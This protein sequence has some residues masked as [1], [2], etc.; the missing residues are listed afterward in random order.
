MLS[1]FLVK[2]LAVSALLCALPLLLY[3]MLVPNADALP[4][5]AQ[6]QGGEKVLG[7]AR[8]DAP[9]LIEGDAIMPRFMRASFAGESV[10]LEN[11]YIKL[12]VFKR[13]GGWGWGEIYAPDG[14]LMAVLDHLGE[15]MLRDQDIP[16]RLEATAYT[17][18][19][20]TDGE[21]LVFQVQSV[22]AQDK[23]AGSSFEEWMRYPF[24]QPV[25]VG[26]VTLTLAPDKPLI[27][28]SC[29]Y[30]STGNFYAR[31]V[32]GPWLRVGQDSFGTAKDDAIFPGVEWLI[33][34]EWSS[35]TD[36][37][38][39]PWAKRVVPHPN[40]VSIPLMTL[41]H[42]GTAITMSWDPLQDATRWFNYRAHRPQPVFASPN[43][44][45]RL[46]NTLM[47]LM[48]PDA[49]VESQENQVYAEPPLMLHLEQRI[50]FDAEIRLSNG[51]SLQGVVDWIT[52]HG[53]PEAALR[54]PFREA[55][56]RI[57]EAYNTNLWHDGE[58]FGIPQR[59]QIRPRP[60]QF[61]ARYLKEYGGTPLATELEEKVAWCNEQTGTPSG[62]V[63]D[64]DTLESRGQ[65][66]LDIQQENG[67]FL[68]EP[69]GRHYRKDDFVI[70]RA[71]I[72]PMGLAQDTALDICMLPATELL[73]LGEQTGNQMFLDAAKKTLEFCMPMTRPEGGDFWET[74]LHAPN[75]LAAGHAAIAYYRGYEVL[76]D[77]RYRDKA[78]YWIRSV[79]PFTHLWEPADIAMMYNTKP[80]LTSSD[81][82]FANWV[83]DHV[84]WE[85]LSVFAASAERG[86]H[87]NVIDPHVDWR[88]YHEGIT[89]AA[90]RWISDHTRND[91]RPHN[92]PE[93]LE[94]YKRGAFDGCYPD[95]FN[96]T[97]GNY[98]GMLIPPDAIARNILAV[99]DYE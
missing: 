52:A 18:E 20:T 16:M 3:T 53:M 50:D 33:D 88:R 94:A 80:C 39:D 73:D 72:E 36:W 79:V 87:W 55:L 9:A 93:T 89:A 62:S 34:D 8:P 17:L 40:K 59:G 26:E 77:A 46:N 92:L 70:A 67:A 27:T 5:V 81:W 25:L 41:S 11:E 60:P 54:W 14:K 84:Q 15:V 63:P 31:Y 30:S 48:V 47:G 1:N 44:I 22:V 65:A 38:K 71:F 45:D 2:K 58:G 56:D 28:M 64:V 7:D 13:I 24:E 42:E 95:T 76:G 68:F 4:E 61:M 21:R 96:S 66:L 49:T 6:A 19:N 82:Y 99:L 78:I 83:R 23:L 90:I 43:F 91:W 57:A 37:F 98:G 35:G 69:D 29:R 74:P 86:I 10:V 32:R 51:N 12:A 85:V 97:T 75:L